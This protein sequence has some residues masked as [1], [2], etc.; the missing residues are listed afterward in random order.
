MRSTVSK[1]QNAPMDSEK[2]E[3]IGPRGEACIIL[4]R[5]GWLPNGQPVESYTL[6]TGDKLRPTDVP[7]EFTTMN[8]A[9]TFRLRKLG[10]TSTDEQP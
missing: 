3:A 10:R 4:K 1:Y 8:G 7:G 2:L 5:Q 6:A 9:R